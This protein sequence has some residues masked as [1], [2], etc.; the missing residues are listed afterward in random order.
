MTFLGFYIG[1]HDSSVAYSDA[2]GEVRYFKL[3]RLTQSKHKRGS[4]E[5]VGELCREKGVRP[6][7]ICF[8]DG[9]RN[10]L[11]CCERG[12]LATRVK[13]I[14]ELFDVPTFCIDHHYGHVLSAWP[15]VCGDLRDVE[16]GICVDGRGDNQVKCSVVESPFCLSR[17][18]LVY[19]DTE[20]CVCLLLNQIGRLMKLTGGE[21]DFAGKIMGAYAYGKVDGRYACACADFL[22]A[23]R[24]QDILA[25]PFR[26]VEIGDLCVRKDQKFFDWLA[27]LQFVLGELLLD[28][29]SRHAVAGKTVYAGGCA[30][31]TVY[32]EMIDSRFHVT[33]PPHCYDGGMSLG[34]IE[35]LALYYDRPLFIPAF[36][37]SQEGEDVGY[38]DEE[39]VTRVCGYLSEG[40]IVGWCQGR[41]EVGPRALGHRSILFNPSVRDGKRIINS[42]IKKR[43]FWRPFAG[44]ILLE[45]GPSIMTGFHEC[46]YMLHAKGVKAEWHERLGGIVHRDGTCRLQTVSDSPELHSFYLLLKA[47][48]RRTGIPA[49]LNTSYNLSGKPIT[50]TRVDIKQAFSELNLDVL[51]VGN[52]IM[53]SKK[54]F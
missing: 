43:E 47:F 39:T 8:S 19:S 9:N 18:K 13:P 49:L 1:G 24:L 38:A 6:D 3:E 48:K 21:L 15:A 53:L 44:S 11:G 26:D 27:S 5:W 2:H 36:P 54:I 34:C 23:G 50:N 31:N 46:P 16:R 7:A 51:C 35:Y 32:N 42:R 29:F 22:R 41:G 40:K 52:E 20:T 25:V 37:F 10:G 30:Q 45:D 14:L 4:V 17:A 12:R 33:I 28:I